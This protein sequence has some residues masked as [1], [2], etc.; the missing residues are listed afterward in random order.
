MAHRRHIALFPLEQLGD[1]EDLDAG[2]NA[3]ERC[4]EAGAGS[5]GAHGLS[6]LVHTE[7]RADLGAL[8]VQDAVQAK[9]RGVIVMG[10]EGLEPSRLAAHDP[11][12]CL[13]ASSSTSP[14]I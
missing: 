6:P 13:S 11:K 2:M 3:P 14:W 1:G 12:S 8:P 10:K 5:S 7:Q 4:I 9:G